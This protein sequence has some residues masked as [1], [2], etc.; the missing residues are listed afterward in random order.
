MNSLF[1]GW[2]QLETFMINRKSGSFFL[3]TGIGNSSFPFTTSR[4][5][6]SNSCLQLDLICTS[7]AIGLCQF[8]LDFV[9]IWSSDIFFLG[10]AGL[11]FITIL[12]VDHD[13]QCPFL[14]SIFFSFHFSCF[15]L[16]GHGANALVILWHVLEMPGCCVVVSLPA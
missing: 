12:I 9:Y 10:S 14:K 8:Q 3:L 5:R 13:F 2:S 15:G 6:Y 1:L 11:I 7:R 16:F 4:V